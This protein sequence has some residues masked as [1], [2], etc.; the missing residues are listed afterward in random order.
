MENELTAVL[1]SN[2]FGISSKL[3]GYLAVVIFLI[4]FNI[5]CSIYSKSPLLGFILTPIVIIG[6][7][8]MGLI[9]VWIGFTAIFPLAYYIF[10]GN[11]QP[12]TTEETK[13]PYWEEYGNNIKQAYKAKFGGNNPEFASEVDNHIRV[14]IHNGKGFTN[15]LAY[16]W[17]KRM[18]KFTESKN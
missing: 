12:E 18:D 8:L 5:S 1:L 13:I 14:M 9:P 15:T 10:I 17:L 11:S 16:D 6:G 2:Y 7:I 4:A 3:V